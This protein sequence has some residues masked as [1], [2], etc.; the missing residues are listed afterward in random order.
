MHVCLGRRW[1]IRVFMGAGALGVTSQTCMKHER[2]RFL[3]FSQDVQAPAITGTGTGAGADAQGPGSASTASEDLP[4]LT[5][6]SHAAAAEAEPMMVDLCSPCKPDKAPAAAA[7]TGAA[8]AAAGSGSAGTGT[9]SG[10][11]SSKPKG[12]VCSLFM[13]IQDRKKLKQQQVGQGQ[14][15][16]WANAGKRTPKVHGSVMSCTIRYA[17]LHAVAHSPVGLMM[18]IQE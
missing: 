2:S 17:V 5:G 16:V 18:K 4:S 8:K 12:P 15:R 3:I 6:P 9:G 7:T 11:E 1:I 13:S 10:G 14:A